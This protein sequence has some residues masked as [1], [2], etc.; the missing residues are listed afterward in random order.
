VQHTATDLNDN[1]PLQHTAKHHCNTLQHTT[2]THC[3]TPQHTTTHL[4]DNTPF[5]HESKT[6]RLRITCGTDSKKA[7]EVKEEN[8]T[9]QNKT[10]WIAY[11]E[12]KRV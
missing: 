1:A 4:N 3:N 2:A 5:Q 6:E 8:S 9:K 11:G 12:N 10:F 7:R